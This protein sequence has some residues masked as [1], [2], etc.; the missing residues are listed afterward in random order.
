MH[1]LFANKTERIF[2]LPVCLHKAVHVEHIVVYRHCI[3]ITT[4]RLTKLWE[5]NATTVATRKAAGD[6]GGPVNRHQGRKVG[7]Q[8]LP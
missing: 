6:K 8:K 4:S 2:L 1:V 3:P 5:D 7:R